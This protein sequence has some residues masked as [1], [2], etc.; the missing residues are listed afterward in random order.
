MSE[1]K[2]LEAYEQLC[3]DFYTS[4]FNS[5]IGKDYNILGKVQI[6]KIQ[7]LVAILKEY[8]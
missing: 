6:N 3:R 8:F 5:F 2:Y 1:Q 7:S 4:F